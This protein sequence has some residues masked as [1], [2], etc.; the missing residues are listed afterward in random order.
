MT[1]FVTILLLK[2]IL[3][4][5]YYNDFSKKLSNTLPILQIP[6]KSKLLF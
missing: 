5:W 4:D 6:N 3:Y 2:T 1:I